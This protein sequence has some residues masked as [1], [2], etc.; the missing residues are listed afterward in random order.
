MAPGVLY[1][2]IYGTPKPRPVDHP[3]MKYLKFRP[4]ML[5]N[6]RRHKVFGVDYPAI[7]PEE[8]GCV[9]GTLVSGLTEGDIWRL[10]IFEGTQYERR[11]VRAKVL[12][13][14]A[15]DEAAPETST[16]NGKA[17]DR[18]N[19]T[20]PKPSPAIEGEEE[21]VEAQT[22]IWFSAPSELESEEWDF[23]EFKREKMDMWTG[24][25]NWG[26]DEEDTN[27]M[28]RDEGFDDVDKAVAELEKTK[29]QDGMG[30]RGV[31]GHI[32]KQLTEAQK[33][34]ETPDWSKG[35]W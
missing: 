7:L 9:R 14:V 33:N 11:H 25:A 20:H 16:K 30:G 4:A 27:G 1:R 18:T 8:G 34:G 5:H 29:N 15:L 28:Q 21:E 26:S 35:A 23:E 6:H 32:G 13:D 22:Y 10:D 12:K 31:N 2:I 24:M 3:A 19:G 17:T